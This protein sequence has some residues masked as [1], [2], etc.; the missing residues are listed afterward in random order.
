V[1]ADFR[2]TL[3]VA[4]FLEQWRGFRI[5]GHVIESGHVGVPLHVRLTGEDVYFEGR[6]VQRDGEAD[7]GEDFFHG[8]DFAI[9]GYGT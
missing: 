1:V 2:I 3:L 9:I 6:G 5:L 7:G 4:H 8:I